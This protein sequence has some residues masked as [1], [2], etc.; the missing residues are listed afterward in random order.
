[1]SQ[2]NK[3]F[4]S[5]FVAV[6]ILSLLLTNCQVEKTLTDA[7]ISLEATETC[8]E[9]EARECGRT[10]AQHDAVL[11]CLHGVQHCEGGTWGEC[12][13]GTIHEFPANETPVPPS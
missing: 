13:E 7:A 9:G 1:M 4:T 11:S 2:S 3:S 5:L 8:D 10:L 12:E 6:S